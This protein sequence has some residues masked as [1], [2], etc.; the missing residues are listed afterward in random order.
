[1]SIK[2]R[3]AAFPKLADGFLPSRLDVI[4]VGWRAGGEM[5]G[6]FRKDLYIAFSI[7]GRCF[8]IKLGFCHHLYSLAPEV[9][10]GNG[11]LI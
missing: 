2:A 3:F 5:G 1:M 9:C 10:K 7:Y 11:N 4:E 6:A 8:S